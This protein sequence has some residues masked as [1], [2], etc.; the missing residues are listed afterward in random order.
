MPVSSH[1]QL[2]SGVPGAGQEH[3]LCCCRPCRITHVRAG[4]KE[5]TRDLR[6]TMRLA[7]LV[8]EVVAASARCTPAEEPGAAGGSGGAAG[9]AGGSSSGEAAYCAA[10]RPLQVDEVSG[11]WEAGHTYGAEVRRESVAPSERVTRLGREI[12]G[13]ASDL[14]LSAS[15]SV[16]VRVDDEKMI[17][18]ALGPAA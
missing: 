7:V 17:V 15:S 8:S 12:A 13:L 16:F 1:H 11:L 6:A 4:V 18:R 10:L 2:Q 9:D 14:P 5:S 3:D